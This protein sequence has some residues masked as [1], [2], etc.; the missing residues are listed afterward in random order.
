MARLLSLYSVSCCYNPHHHAFVVYS[1]PSKHVTYYYPAGEVLAQS[2]PALERGTHPVAIIADLNAA[3]RI[4]LD[5]VQRI[6][7]PIDV[8]SDSQMLALIRTSI[9]TKLSIRVQP[10]FD[11]RAHGMAERGG[12]STR[13]TS[14]AM[15]VEKVPPRAQITRCRNADQSSR[16]ALCYCRSRATNLIRVTFVPGTVCLQFISEEARTGSEGPD[17][18]AEGCD[19]IPED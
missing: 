2:V 9:G 17:R 16:A 18:S 10:R 5:V 13:W 14:S 3:L 19:G 15:R 12:G 7:V 8:S 6:S 4:A 11:G 1:F